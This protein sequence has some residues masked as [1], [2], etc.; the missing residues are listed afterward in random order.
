MKFNLFF[1]P[2][3]K[4]HSR[5]FRDILD[6]NRIQKQLNSIKNDTWMNLYNVLSI[7][8]ED[9]EE[10]RKLININKQNAWKNGI[11]NWIPAGEIKFKGSIIPIDLIFE[12]V[13]W[14]KVAYED[15]LNSTDKDK[16]LELANDKLISTVFLLLDEENKK[17][18]EKK[19]AQNTKKERE[20]QEK[21]EHS[22]KHKLLEQKW[23][24]VSIELTD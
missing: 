11:N 13:S 12:R 14:L 16:E 24:W 17:K 10:L 3:M 20:R 18:Q 22:L 9:V 2:T 15:A 1:R 7:S 8:S 5:E 23:R 4:N 6:S 19:N 21:A